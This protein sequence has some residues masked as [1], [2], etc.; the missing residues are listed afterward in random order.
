MRES[1]MRK[2]SR[3][4]YCNSIE[5][6]VSNHHELGTILCLCRVCGNRWGQ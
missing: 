2:A 4:T 6:D 5:V 1:V 3:C